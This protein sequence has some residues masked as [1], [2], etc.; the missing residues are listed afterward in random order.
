[1]YFMCARVYFNDETLCQQFPDIIDGQSGFAGGKC[2]AT[3]SKK[4]FKVT[5]SFSFESISTFSG[6]A[7]CLGKVA[8]LQKEVEPF[9]TVIRE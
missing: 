3:I 2:V 9:I 4:R 6:K 7:L 5:S 1:M 8:L